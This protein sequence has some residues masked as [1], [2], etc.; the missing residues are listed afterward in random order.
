M[1]DFKPVTTEE[2]EEIHHIYINHNPENTTLAE[3]LA[4]AI[5]LVLA[6]RKDDDAVHP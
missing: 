5:N 1:T 2:A 4:F 3:D 6:K